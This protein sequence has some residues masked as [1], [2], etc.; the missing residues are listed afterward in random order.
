MIC[1]EQIVC[2]FYDPSLILQLSEFEWTLRSSV[3]VVFN[4][5]LP[6]DATDRSKIRSDHHRR[7][8]NVSLCPLSFNVKLYVFK[9]HPIT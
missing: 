3:L 5:F 1:L 7:F 9:Q 4:S 2:F 8:F 6:I